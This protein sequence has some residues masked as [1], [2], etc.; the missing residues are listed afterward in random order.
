MDSTTQSVGDQ[1]VTFALVLR[2]LRKH[3]FAVLSTADEKGTPHSAGVNYG[4]SRP[5]Q[6][7]A[8]YVMTR[9]HL[10]KTRN[11]AQNP[12]VSLVI[13]VTRRLL[14]FLPPPTIQ[15]RGRAEILDWTDAE[16]T[17]VFRHFWMGRRI[18]KAYNESHRRGETRIC[19]LKITPDPVIA[20]YMV[21][22]NI[23]ELRKRMESGAARVIIPPDYGS[24][25]P[26]SPTHDLV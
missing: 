4:V 13:P 1:K 11:I 10:K 25:T 16:G 24:S 6:D 19:F 3:D 14:W 18:L 8:L 7:L 15:M 12:I 17:E 5:G 20:T 26:T 23:W 21:G 2:Q 22:Y 9:R